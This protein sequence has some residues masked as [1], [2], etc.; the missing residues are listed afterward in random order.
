MA[1]IVKKK[2]KTKAAR[3]PKVKRTRQQARWQRS[4]QDRSRA[5]GGP[6]QDGGAAQGRLT[7]RGPLGYFRSAGSQA[8]DPAED[9]SARLL[10][11]LMRPA[12][13]Q[14]NPQARR[15]YLSNFRRARA[16]ILVNGYLRQFRRNPKNVDLMQQKN[17]KSL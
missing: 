3:R 7:K 1:K 10:T 8:R 17:R 2:R 11:T 15:S 12:F 5:H 16:P 9:I 14:V 13:E 4:P 6:A